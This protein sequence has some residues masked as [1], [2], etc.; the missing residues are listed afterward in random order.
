MLNRDL[1]EG[2]VDLY[3]KLSGTGAT[4]RTF[5]GNADGRITII[6]GPGKITGRRLDLW[7]SDLLPTLL[8]P[9]WQ[10]QPVTDMN[11]MVAHIELQEGLAKIEDILLDTRRITIAGSGILDLETEELDVFIAPR[12]KRASL[13]S[14]ANPVEIT[15][16]LSQ[17]EVSVARLPTRRWLG[18]GAGIAGSFINPAFLILVLSD[19]GTGVANPCVAA[20]ERAHE[21][22]E[23][24]S[25]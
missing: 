20:V 25:Q 18:R 21:I 13:V 15:G 10:R 14:L 12:P 22:A 9:R 24:D 3:V 7:A 6:A 23:V 17:P 11:C 1:I 5:L 16:T 4:R 2:R 19:T 8:S